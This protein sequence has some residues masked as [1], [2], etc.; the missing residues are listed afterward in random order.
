MKN[1]YKS[2][3]LFNDIKDV[4]LQTWN[5]CAIVFNLTAD[6]GPSAAKNYVSQFSKDD[7]KKIYGMFDTIKKFG[8]NEVRKQCTPQVLEA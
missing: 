5:R 8:Y 4:K 1:T 7:Q 2:S 3:P 6:E